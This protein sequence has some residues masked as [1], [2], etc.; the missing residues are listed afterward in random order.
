MT[1]SP[2]PDELLGVWRR[3]SIQLI[4]A[5]GID[6]A[7]FETAEVY[8]FQARSRF[9]DLRIPRRSG[10]PLSDAEAFGGTQTWQPPSLRFHHALD[11]SGKPGADQGDLSWDGATLV[12]HGTFEVDGEHCQYVERWTQTIA[13]TG[14]DI[15][16]WEGVSDEGVLKGLAIRIADQQ[17][18]LIKHDQTVD[19]GRWCFAAGSPKLVGYLGT[20]ILPDFSVGSEWRRIE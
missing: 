5:P 10:V 12:E 6:S 7:P 20:P 18:V 4:G 16:V 19:A 13:S 2:I 11:R 17:L 14:R 1:E 9:A 8:W 3:E 15:R